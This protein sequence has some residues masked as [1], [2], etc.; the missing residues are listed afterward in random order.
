MNASAAKARI[1]EQCGTAFVVGPNDPDRFCGRPCWYLSKRTLIMRACAHCG[2][3][4][5]TR[6][7][8][9]RKGGGKYHSRACYL[10]HKTTPIGER[11]WRYAERR[12]GC[13]GWSGSLNSHGYGQLATSGHGH[14]MGAHR[15]SWEIHFGPIPPGMFVCHRCDNPPCTNPE[16]LFLATNAENTADKVAK[17]RQPRG[18]RM[19]Q[20]KL[21]DEQVARIRER[22][23]NGQVKQQKD[24]CAEFGVSPAAISMILSDK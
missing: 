15:V 18:E 2:I 20:A 12:P 21:T 8:E 9:I 11:F 16:H 24:L 14:P 4:F 3:P 5:E 19:A 10:A 7:G 17:G 6:P 1:C 13:W 23:A 22:W